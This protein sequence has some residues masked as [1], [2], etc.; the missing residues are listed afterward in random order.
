MEYDRIHR[1]DER[2]AR[3]ALQFRLEFGQVA[4]EWTE[5]SA[6]GLETSSR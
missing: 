2:L 4:P 3:M 6:I 1:F 5:K